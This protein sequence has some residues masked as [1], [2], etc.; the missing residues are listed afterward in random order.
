MDCV[1]L[2]G[3]GGSPPPP[4]WTLEAVVRTMADAMEPVQDVTLAGYCSGSAIALLWALR[5]PSAVRRLVLIEPFAYVP[6]YF[7]LFLAGAPGRRAYEFAFARDAG[8][9]LVNGL[10]RRRHGREGDF[11]GAF[12]RLN[13]EVVLRYLRMFR[14]VSLDKFSGLRIPVDL[15][16]GSRTFG[17]VRD[18]VARFQR[19]WPHARRFE[20]P[21]L[22]HLTMAGGA[23]EIARI[24]FQKERDPAAPA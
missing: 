6:W 7:R 18:S 17:A 1:D 11:T 9:A 3:Y 16:W 15:V 8:R 13:H 12:A 4:E 24:L 5:Q 21:G 20:L 14:T 19:R 2:P 23:G 10:L 22:G